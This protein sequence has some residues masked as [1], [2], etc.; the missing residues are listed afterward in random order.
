MESVY[1]CI[2]L[3][4]QEVNYVKKLASTDYFSCSSIKF[5][6]EIFT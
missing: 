6:N 1:V 3:F 5:L 4:V 2:V